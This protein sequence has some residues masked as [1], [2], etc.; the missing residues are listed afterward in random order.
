LHNI[1]SKVFQ[2]HLILTFW[3]SLCC[4]SVQNE[5]AFIENQISINK[6]VLVLINKHTYTDELK[7]YNQSQAKRMSM[8]IL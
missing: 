4:E 6:S 3:F 5:T 7:H 8:I 2:I 1:L